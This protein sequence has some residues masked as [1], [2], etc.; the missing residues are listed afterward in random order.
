MLSCAKIHPSKNGVN[1]KL[2]AIFTPQNAFCLRQ[3]TL[4]NIGVKNLA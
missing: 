4:K 3:K 1:S 2:E